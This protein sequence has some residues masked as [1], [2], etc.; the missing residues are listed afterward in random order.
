MKT[1]HSYKKQLMADEARGRSALSAQGDGDAS[2][3]R[4]TTKSNNV[5][6]NRALAKPDCSRSGQ[7]QRNA[8]QQ[9]DTGGGEVDVGV[10]SK[11][12]ADDTPA[13]SAKKEGAV[14]GQDD[15]RVSPQLHAQYDDDRYSNMHQ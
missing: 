13:S 2:P 4:S 7:R 5:L 8:I 14:A 9:L 3:A 1:R 15:N 6:Q 11:H 12:S 10:R